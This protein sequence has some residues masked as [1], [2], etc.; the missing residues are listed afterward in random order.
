MSSPIPLSHKEKEGNLRITITQT[1]PPAPTPSVPSHDIATPPL[2]LLLVLTM[3]RPTDL[4]HTLVWNHSPRGAKARD[5]A[6]V[7]HMALGAPIRRCEDI[8]RR[9]GGPILLRGRAVRPLLRAL[10]GGRARAAARGAGAG[11]GL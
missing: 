3:P 11:L 4:T 7:A 10:R 5:V 6:R 9:G 1:I 8:A 2:A